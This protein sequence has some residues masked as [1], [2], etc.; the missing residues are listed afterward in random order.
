MHS[1]FRLDQPDIFDL[2]PFLDRT[3][4]TFH[5]Q[6]LDNDDGIAVYKDIAVGVFIDPF[7]RVFSLKLQPTFGTD[8]D[9]AV[10][11]HILAITL[12]TI[13]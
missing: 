6:I 4:S 13:R 5:F 8:E 1:V 2:C 11:I 10:R 12:R 3:G 7:F 9:S